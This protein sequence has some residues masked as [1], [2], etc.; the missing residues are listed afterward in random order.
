MSA[1]TLSFSQTD[2]SKATPHYSLPTV[3]MPNADLPQYDIIKDNF[4]LIVE[5]DMDSWMVETLNWNKNVDMSSMSP[6]GNL[7]GWN[8]LFP[9]DWNLI[10]SNEQRIHQTSMDTI[11]LDCSVNDI[12]SPLSAERALYMTPPIC[13]SGNSAFPMSPLSDPCSTPDPI[14]NFGSWEMDQNAADTHNMLPPLSPSVAYSLPSQTSPITC[15]SHAPEDE[16]W[17]NTLEMPDG[18]TRRT[19]NW[20]PVDST[21]GFII[22]SHNHIEENDASFAPGHGFQDIQGAFIKEPRAQ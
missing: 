2:E 5:N 14:Y 19:S 8:T 3:P 21:A 1:S 17:F 7:E 22:G 20:L 16:G 4:P 11:P 13:P 12:S 6:V 9:G 10:Q 15:P 18:S